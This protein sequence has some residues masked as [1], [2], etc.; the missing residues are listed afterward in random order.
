MSFGPQNA[1]ITIVKNFQVITNEFSWLLISYHVVDS[2][3][4]AKAK[5]EEID[6][7]VENGILAFLIELN[8]LFHLPFTALWKTA[9]V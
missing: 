6:G 8:M 2:G 3:H 1:S 9:P 7:F 5:I 4:A